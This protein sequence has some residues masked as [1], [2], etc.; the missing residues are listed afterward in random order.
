MP[1]VGNNQGAW[2]MTFWCRI[3]ASL[4]MCRVLL[5]MMGFKYYV[6]L[7]VHKKPDADAKKSSKP[8]GH[9]IRVSEI[10]NC[11]EILLGYRKQKLIKV[12]DALEVMYFVP[13]RALNIPNCSRFIMELK[14]LFCI[15]QRKILANVAMIIPK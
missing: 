8:R 9:D 5:E 4:S 10:P 2:P 6:H 15:L 14:K 7:D 11:K 13:L 1:I 3:E 12:L